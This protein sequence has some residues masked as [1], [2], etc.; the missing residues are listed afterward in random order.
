MAGLRR[1]D[2]INL[3]V[4]PPETGFARFRQVRSGARHAGRV[5]SGLIRT[6]PVQSGHNDPDVSELGHSKQFQSGSGLAQSD[7]Y[8]PTDF[9]SRDRDVLRSP[10]V[11]G[12]KRPVKRSS[13]NDSSTTT[14]GANIPVKRRK[15]ALHHSSLHGARKLVTSIF[16]WK[17]LQEAEVGCD[18]VSHDCHRIRTTGGVSTSVADNCFWN[19]ETVSMKINLSY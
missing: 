19:V 18:A 14:D 11:N 16:G 7:S 2:I 12:V 15:T 10:G 9:R 4:S 13:A 8:C 6:G 5:Q 3:I 17:G 1:T